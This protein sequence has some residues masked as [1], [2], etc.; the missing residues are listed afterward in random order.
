MTSVVFSFLCLLRGWSWCLLLRVKSVSVVVVVV[1]A[2]LP[3]SS[4]HGVVLVVV[5]QTLCTSSSDSSSM[6]SS[7]AWP[8]V[9]C[10]NGGITNVKPSPANRGHLRP[11]PPAREADDGP[12][13]KVSVEDT[14]PRDFGV[15]SELLLELELLLPAEMLLSLPGDVDEL[16]LAV[17]LLSGLWDPKFRCDQVSVWKSVSIVCSSIHATFRGV[18]MTHWLLHNLDLGFRDVI[19]RSA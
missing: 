8:F 13:E 7:Q 5:G 19:L 9:R 1:D 3:A 10:Q 14:R 11:R 16:L 18:L 4:V 6:M 17:E 15:R 12:G 2:L